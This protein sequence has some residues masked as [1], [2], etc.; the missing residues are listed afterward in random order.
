MMAPMQLSLYPEFLGVG[1][2]IISR[3]PSSSLAHP[4][5]ADLSKAGCP[6][7]AKEVQVVHSSGLPSLALLQKDIPWLLDHDFIRVAW[8]T[9]ERTIFFR[10]FIIPEDDISSRN[11][12]YER[13]KF[14][15]EGSKLLRNLLC[16]IT[17]SPAA[18]TACQGLPASLDFFLENSVSLPLLSHSEGKTACLMLV[19]TLGVAP[20]T[21]DLSPTTLTVIP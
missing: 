4:T 21:T 18:W 17:R 11:T 1:T 13:H 12:L 6:L 2:L 8:S 19:S 9:V 10:I 20:P 14:L 7:I 3:K 16:H 5:W 15:S